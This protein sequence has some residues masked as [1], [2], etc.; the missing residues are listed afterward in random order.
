[1]QTR[2]PC[3]HACDPQWKGEWLADQFGG[4]PATSAHPVSGPRPDRD[5]M[6]NYISAII[7]PAGQQPSRWA[8]EE[9][10]RALDLLRQISLFAV[11][12]HHGGFCRIPLSRSRIVAGSLCCAQR[13]PR[14]YRT[15]DDTAPSRGSG[16][17]DT[18][19]AAA[20]MNVLELEMNPF[21]HF[22]GGWCVSER[23][24][25]AFKAFYPNFFGGHGLAANLVL[26]MAGRAEWVATINDKRSREER[27]KT[28]CPSFLR[29]LAARD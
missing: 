3:D 15:V 23:N 2:Q 21:G 1:M 25:V 4:Q 20:V 17:R 27:W 14:W 28:A 11:G 5:D 18:C 19:H 16:S 13:R 9:M 29:A 24:A 12:E 7:V 8:G 26:Q 6:L 22:R 10:E